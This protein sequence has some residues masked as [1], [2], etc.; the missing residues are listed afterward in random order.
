MLRFKFLSSLLL[1]SLCACSGATIPEEE[2]SGGT[3]SSSAGESSTD[4]LGAVCGDGIAEADEVCDGA[5][6]A[7]A[8]CAEL[9][10][11]E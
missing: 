2:S 9:D 3:E 6:L 1:L 5:D 11:V 10:R 8:T 7:G 4:T